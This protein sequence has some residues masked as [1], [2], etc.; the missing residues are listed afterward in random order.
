[1]LRWSPNIPEQDSEITLEAGKQAV[2][3]LN[4]QT[5]MCSNPDFARII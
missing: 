2:N 5:T 3:T 1:M 4:S